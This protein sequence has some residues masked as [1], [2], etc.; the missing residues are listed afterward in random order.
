MTFL[1]MQTRVGELIN[2]EVTGDTKT[3]TLTSVKANLN[4]GYRDVVNAVASTNENYYWRKTMANLVAGQAT[5][6]LPTD[7]KKIRRIEVGYE[8]I[9]DMRRPQRLDR[10]SRGEANLV[11][12]VSAPVFYVVGNNIELDPTPSEN[13]TN[14]L[15]LWYLEHPSD[16][17]NNTDEPDVPE[18]YEQLPIVYAVAKAKLQ[19]GLDVE[20][21]SQLSEFE[22]RLFKMKAELLSR[23]VGD[24]DFVQIT[25]EF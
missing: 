24:N 21:R 7:A 15:Q 11:Y 5:Y 4:I 20:H 19:L 14:G 16:M 1:E 6:S 2:Q 10:D 12:S 25:D 18:G 9:S 17:S 8:S 22:D 23:G 3:I 13:V